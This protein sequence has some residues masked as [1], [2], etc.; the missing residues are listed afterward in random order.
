MTEHEHD[1][2]SY[3]WPLKHRSVVF[4]VGGFEGRWARQIKERYHPNLHVF[5]PQPWAYER[6]RYRLG[7]PF[8]RI[9]PYALGDRDAVLPMGDFETDGCSFVKDA[10]WYAA[11]PGQAHQ[12]RSEGRMRDIVTVL[13]EIMP[14]QRYRRPPLID[15][16]LVNI[17][18]YEFTLLPYMF[19]HG[20]WPVRLMVQFHLLNNTEDDYHALRALIGQHYGPPIWD[21]GMVL[22][23]W[24]RGPGAQLL[25]ESGVVL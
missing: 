11:H 9:H 20:I 12:R 18:G 1:I 21:Y 3:N 17:E 15:L 19:A 2:R 6:L 8:D 23:A 4:E 25:S 22:A 13:P 14:H 16:M 7:A 5:E 10:A 24:E